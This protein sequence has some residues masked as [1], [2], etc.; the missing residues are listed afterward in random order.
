M[1]FFP[2]CN[3]KNSFVLSFS[4]TNVFFFVNR[5][6]LVPLDPKVLLVLLDLL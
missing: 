3:S 2:V 4:L 5:D 6:L 1:G